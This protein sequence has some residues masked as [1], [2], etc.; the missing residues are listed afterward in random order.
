LHAQ[1][2]AAALP[3]GEDESLGQARQ[4]LLVAAAEVGE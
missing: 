2:A 3:A 4:A 1:A